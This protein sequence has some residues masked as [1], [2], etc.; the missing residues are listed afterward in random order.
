[1]ECSTGDLPSKA[2]QRLDEVNSSKSS[3]DRVFIGLKEQNA[4]GL[5]ESVDIF[6]FSTL[7][8]LIPLS[9]GLEFGKLSKFQLLNAPF[10]W[11]NILSGHILAMSLGKPG[12]V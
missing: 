1:M 9:F 7:V 6:G 12:I 10:S 4:R 5:I 3:A 8:G 11:T 2:C